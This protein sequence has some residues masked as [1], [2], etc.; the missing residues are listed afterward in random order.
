MN[1]NLI[2][3][4]DKKKLL[5]TAQASAKYR[6][7]AMPH[8]IFAGAPGCGKTTMARELSETLMLPYVTCS[9]KSIVK[10]ADVL[11]LLENLDH[12]GYDRTGNRIGEINPSILF[13]DEIHNLNMEVQEE[14]G[15]AMEEFRLPTE[16]KSSDYYWVPYFTLI[17]ATTNDGLLSKP[18]LDRFKFRFIFEPY[19]DE[20]MVKIAELHAKK[21]KITITAKAIRGLVSRSRG[22]PRI[23]VG[24]LEHCRDAMLAIN[25]GITTSFLVEQVFSDLGIDECGLSRTELKLLQTLMNSERPIGL[26]TLSVTTNEAEKTL[27]NSV[28]PHLVREGFMII[29]GSG[30][31]ITTLGRNYLKKGG[32]LGNASK[33]TISADAVRK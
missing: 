28:E 14:L 15:I 24:Y 12:E 7:K 9:S 21:Q 8:M 5:R 17:G 23:L 1:M 32:Y 33:L 29:S 25:S 2:G 19:E 3:H 27:S 4:E 11:D 10:R 20:E 31:A 18:F 13:I 22:T 16:Q 26:K 30:R 6:N